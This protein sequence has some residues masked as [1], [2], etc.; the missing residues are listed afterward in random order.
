MTTQ[1]ANPW[2]S[3]KNRIDRYL[4]GESLQPWSK[5]PSME[6][7]LAL[8]KRSRVHHNSVITEPMVRERDR[9]TNEVCDYYGTTLERVRTSGRCFADI[10][11]RVVLYL[12]I[13][14]RLNFGPTNMSYYLCRDHC[15]MISHE[16]KY[17]N[18]TMIDTLRENVTNAL[19]DLHAI[20]DRRNGLRV[21]TCVK[22]HARKPKANVPLWQVWGAGRAVTPPKRLGA[23]AGL[24]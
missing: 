21:L 10:E 23:H 16:R 9:L 15:T 12:L 2:K 22:T 14:A 8:E 17:R 6:H 1:K 4:Q 11:P 18:G 5:G 13:R 20:A 3:R 19:I 7:Y 24:P